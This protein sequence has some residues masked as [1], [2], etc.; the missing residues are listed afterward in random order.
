MALVVRDV[1]LAA[2]C[3][4]IVIALV[5]AGELFVSPAYC[6]VR[7]CVPIARVEMLKLN[8]PVL[9][10][11]CVAITALPSCKVRAPVGATPLPVRTDVNI[12]VVPTSTGLAGLARVSPV[13]AGE[14]VSTS[15]AEVLVV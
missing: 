15:D 11:F 14:I 4:V 9:V 10:T 5:L 6:A 8:V 12:T 1:L 7:V 13:V 3:T 2:C